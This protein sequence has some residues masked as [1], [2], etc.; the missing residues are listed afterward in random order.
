MLARR[1]HILQ[2]RVHGSTPAPTARRRAFTLI[3]LLVVIAIIA[4]LVSILA[5]SLGHLKSTIKRIICASDM[6]Q[7]GIA[8]N[9]YTKANGG[10]LVGSNTYWPWDWAGPW[11]DMQ[12][13]ALYRY[14]G[15]PKVYYC[16]NPINPAYPI[17]YSIAGSLNGERASRWTTLV[18][19]PHPSAALMI[20]EEDDWRGYN[21][22][23]WMLVSID[24]W[25]DYVAGN[26][27][28]GDNLVF[29]DGHV[30]YW[31]WREYNTL[32][33]PHHNYDFFMPDPGNKDLTRLWRVW[34]GEPYAVSSYAN[35]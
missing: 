16:T 3:E 4:L 5:P 33:F 14:V 25:E 28:D 19:I 15:S 10:S 9:A 30:E 29:V 8:W 1:G 6:R 17:S 24:Q 11:G 12:G 2:A 13:G 20:I 21:V 27:D 18:G 7:L 35:P 26:H 22:N 34:A 32:A 31:K 23:S